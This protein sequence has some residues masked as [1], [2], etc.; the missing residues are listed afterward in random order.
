MR[1][2]SLLPAFSPNDATGTLASELQML[3]R[4]LGFRSELFALEIH[5]DLRD[6]ARPASELSAEIGPG[7]AVLYHHGIGSEL[8]P[9]LSS[10]P[11]HKVLAYHNITPSRFFQPFDP[12]VARALDDGRL[13]LNALSE[14]CDSALAFSKFSG[15]E[16]GKLGFEHVSVIPPPLEPWRVCRAGDER[17]FRRLFDG[18]T[19]NLLF[20]GRVVPNKRI[21]DLIA[22]TE[23]LID[24]N[25]GRDFRLVVAGAYQRAS[26][27]FARLQEL[28]EPIEDRVV[29]LGSLTQHELCAAYRAAHL[30]VSMSEHEGF[31]LPICEA[32]A[33]G[34]PVI[35]YDGGAVAE[36]MGRAGVLFKP[37]RMERVAALCEILLD[38]STRRRQLIEGGRM[39][40]AQLSPDATLTP[41]AQALE[42]LLR[43]RPTRVSKPRAKP[44]V[45]FV[46]H[47]YGPEVV[48]GAE[49]HS[50]ALAQRMAKRWDVEVITTC[51]A[52]YLTW[53]NVY[54]SGRSLDGPVA[55][56]RFPTTQ[57]RDMRRFNALSRRLFGR[58]QDR[59]SEERW[60]GAQGPRS[61][62]LLD[63]L[64]SDL[65][66]H[67]GFVFFTYLYEPTAIGL[68]IV[69]R[70]A[71]FV[72]TA[73]DEPPLRFGLYRQTFSAPAGILFN[74]PE[75][76]AL[77]EGLFQMDG[78]HKEVVGI[79]VE[80]EPG[81][82]DPLLD[83]VGLRG[84]YLLY[85]GRIAPG[86]GIPELLDGYAKLRQ[87]LGPAVPALV[88][89]GANE[90]RLKNQPGVYV[91]GSL[92]D[93]GKWG[94]LRGALAVVVPSA[95]ESLS[96]AAL[97]AWSV[98]R[99]VVAN[100]ESPVLNGQARRSAAAVTYRGP[101]E[102]A[103]VTG[104]LL[105]DAAKMARLSESGRS[106]VQESY[107]WDR[108]T[109]RYEQLLQSLVLRPAGATPRSTERTAARALRRE[110]Q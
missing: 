77:C 59:L 39:R 84:P 63:F 23:R 34:V 95:Q 33:A 70:R 103:E 37:K 44:R 7:D 101:A 13:Q 69:G 68:P 10:L 26:A 100:G 74:T 43:L 47:R 78:V 2:H 58:A 22:L 53:E 6:L 64:A 94:A 97:E 73:H 14:M 98:G 20:V 81:D 108:V 32:M 96:L 5:P 57:T 92:S 3:L 102:F 106:F 105:E 31:G 79:G 55:V 1:F 65:A 86:K 21:E 15:S 80:A 66:D 56:R 60:L 42:P 88:L 46:V 85:L 107:S 93:A 40:A 36:A 30:F 54:A 83:K 87:R 9:L 71:L 11:A 67:D 91:P 61:P 45:G 48:G 49:R 76:Q 52:D 24:R 18:K 25:L 35:A 109:D 19:Q 17:I 28:A 38:D 72:P 50:R 90:M 104:A 89:C 51:A 4:R 29:F 75:E 16:L 62:E 99:P 41:L 12:A 110:A 8:V 82:P 27:Y